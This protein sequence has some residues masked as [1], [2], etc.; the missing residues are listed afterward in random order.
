MPAVGV[1]GA[2]SNCTWAARVERRERE[3][4]AAVEQ[5]GFS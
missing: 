3:K 1:K 5:F 4:S 2:L